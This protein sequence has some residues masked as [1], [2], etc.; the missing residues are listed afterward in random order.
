MA[1]TYT[2]DNEWSRDTWFDTDPFQGDDSGDSWEESIMKVFASMAKTKLTK[3]WAWTSCNPHI[4]SQK[5]KTSS[6]VT[7]SILLDTSNEIHICI[8]TELHIAIATLS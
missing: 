4:P 2:K 6:I 8:M 5:L 1:T 7:V 3:Q